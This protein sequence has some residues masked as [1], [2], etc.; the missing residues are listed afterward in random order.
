MTGAEI[1]KMGPQAKKCQ[2]LEAGRDQEEILPLEPSESALLDILILTLG[3]LFWTSDL[4]NCKRINLCS[5]IKPPSL[6]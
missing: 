4:W 1:E 6:W 2:P 3:D 5:F